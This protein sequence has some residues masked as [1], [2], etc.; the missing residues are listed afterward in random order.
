MKRRYKVL[1]C[2]S[3]LRENIS[4]H[5][6]FKTMLTGLPV[7]EN[8]SE[9]QSATLKPPHFCVVL[10]LVVLSLVVLFLVVLFLCSSFF[11]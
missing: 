1:D 9:D 10:S 3:Y 7:S 8:S 2:T 5:V 6:W 4:T 11:M